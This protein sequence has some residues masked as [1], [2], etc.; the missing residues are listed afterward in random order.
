MVLSCCLSVLPVFFCLF[1]PME[2]FD[3]FIH[4]LNCF[5]PVW[6]NVSE[7]GGAGAASSYH[8]KN[9]LEKGKLKERAEGEVCAV[10][11]SAEA[12]QIPEDVL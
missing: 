10:L 6:M 5:F 12:L 11:W 4:Y 9:E 8:N 1:V 2:L 7:D 3:I